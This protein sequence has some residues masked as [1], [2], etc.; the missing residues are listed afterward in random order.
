MI[1]NEGHFVLNLWSFCAQLVRNLISCLS[2]LAEALPNPVQ[3]NALSENFA[4]TSV[5][6][7]SGDTRGCCHTFLDALL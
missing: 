1:L 5:G 3:S 2:H 6:V 7:G 4:L